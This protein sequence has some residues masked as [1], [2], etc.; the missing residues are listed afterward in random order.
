MKNY[1][2]IL[3]SIFFLNSCAYKQKSQNSNDIN[4]DNKTNQLDFKKFE[5]KF[6][7]K[8]SNLFKEYN[9]KGDLILG[10]VDKSGLIYS[11]AFNQDLI[12]GKTSS[13]NNDSPIYI[14]SHTKALT[15]TLLKILEDEGKIDLNKTLYHYIPELTFNGRVDTKL[16][17]VRSLLNHTSG[18]SCDVVT[19]KTAYLG[20]SGNNEEIIND[21]NLYSEINTSGKFRYS[22]IGPI[23]AGIIVEKITGNTWKE[24]MKKRIFDPLGMVNTSSNISDYNHS[25][26]RP[27]VAV[28]KDTVY[29]SG[30]YKQD[31]TMHAAGGTLSSINDLSKW[32]VAN[33]NND[34]KLISSIDSWKS[35][36]ESTTVQDRTYFTY[37]RHGYS[38]GWDIATYQK[39][40]IL[41]R[42]GGYAGISFHLSFIPEKEIGIIAFSNDNRMTSTHLAANY[43]YNLI[44]NVTD[45]EEIFNREKEKLTTSFNHKNN[46][47]LLNLSNELMVNDTNKK[48]AGIYKNNVGL[49]DISIT[50]NKSRYEVKW[51]I[52]EGHIYKKQGKEKSYIVSLGALSQ[53]LD[54]KKDSLLI[55]GVKFE[56]SK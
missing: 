16:I 1:L 20:Y 37:K 12:H 26:I 43:A 45:S 8:I 52:L 2:L 10:I 51:G 3:I 18:I 23:I 5:T 39:D 29:Q 32:L 27:L 56:K 22:N 15:G 13:L 55:G 17:T 35:L 54:I 41:M 44:N 38:L 40:T 49:P 42:F 34:H 9:L 48:I 28:A 53:S 30:F 24:E 21:F 31:I 50:E 33:I 11:Y 4:T 7:S 25:D 14:A 6:E 47:L 46:S 19:Y 36:H